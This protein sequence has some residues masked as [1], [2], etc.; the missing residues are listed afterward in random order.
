ML[1]SVVKV[2]QKRVIIRDARTPYYYEHFAKPWSESWYSQEKLRIT[3]RNFLWALDEKKW[4][5]LEDSFREVEHRT[6]P[7]VLP[8]S[9]KWK[10]DKI[11]SARKAHSLMFPEI[12]RRMPGLCVHGIYKWLGCEVDDLVTDPVEGNGLVLYFIPYSQKMP[13]DLPFQFRLRTQLALQVTE[14][15]W[16]HVVVWTP[17]EIRTALVKKDDDLWYYNLLPKLTEFYRTYRVPY[18]LLRGLNQDKLYSVDM[19]VY[20]AIYAENA[21]VTDS[22]QGPLKHYPPFTEAVT[23]LGGTPK[24]PEPQVVKVSDATG[25]QVGQ[26]DDA[27][28]TNRDGSLPAPSPK[29]NLVIER[30][31][32]K[33]R[34]RTLRSPRAR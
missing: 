14:L 9:V 11:P 31:S 16:A 7:S 5:G 13:K 26:L 17:H 12:K 19:E 1:Q 10:Y 28:P 4:K 3:D 24:I 8:A 29:K 18:Y 27:D 33:G 23:G 6:L 21:G 32:P 15:A 25:S 22:L 20:N 34:T 30:R 2:E